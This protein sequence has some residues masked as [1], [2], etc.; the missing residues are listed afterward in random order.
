[1][2][3]LLCCYYY[4]ALPPVVVRSVVISLSV[5]PLAYLENHTTIFHQFFLYMLLVA[6]A[7]S[8]SDGNAIHYVR[9]G[10]VHV[11][12]F[13]CNG[14]NSRRSCIVWVF[15]QFARWQHRGQSLRRRLHL[16]VMYAAFFQLLQ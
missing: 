1:M 3:D 12:M 11:V 15:V 14:G 10:F 2:C 5:C 9:S 7:R 4:F 6:V 13:S 16:V 8:Y